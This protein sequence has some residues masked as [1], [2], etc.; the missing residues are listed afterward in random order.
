MASAA[1][2]CTATVFIVWYIDLK[3]TTFGATQNIYFYCLQLTLVYTLHFFSDVQSV[4]HELF[5]FFI[6]PNWHFLTRESVVADNSLH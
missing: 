2:K 3:F 5:V 6:G 1:L 4:Y